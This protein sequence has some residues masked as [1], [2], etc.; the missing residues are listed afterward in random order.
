MKITERQTGDIT[1]VDVEGEMRFGD[2]EEGFCDALNKMLESGRAHFVINM[3]DVP[4]VDSAGLSQLVRSCGAARKRG[5]ELKLLNLT[6]RVRDL[7][8][9]TRL[10]SVIQAFESEEEA[11]GSFGDKQTT[12]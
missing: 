2:G 3:A 9:M 4:Y 12:P 7:L 1:I 11:V 6:R 5:G 8:A 10:L